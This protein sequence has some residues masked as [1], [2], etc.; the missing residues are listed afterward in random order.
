MVGC[1]PFKSTK[2]QNDQSDNQM[3]FIDGQSLTSVKFDFTN[4][5]LQS[6]C[7]F[8]YL[9]LDSCNENQSLMSMKCCFTKVFLQNM[10]IFYYLPH[11]G[12][13]ENQMDKSGDDHEL[14]CMLAL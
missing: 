3:V 8:Y 2:P 6:M 14:D 7:I 5:F 1:F 12:C 10:C 9:P 4:V 11:N 13:S